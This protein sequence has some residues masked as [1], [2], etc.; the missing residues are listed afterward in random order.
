PAAAPGAAPDEPAPATTYAPGDLVQ[1][2]DLARVAFALVADHPGQVAGRPRRI[3]NLPAS[4]LN[5]ILEEAPRYFGW[6]AA[7][8]HLGTVHPW[9]SVVAGDLGHPIRWRP[10]GPP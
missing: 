4:I 8:G 7:Q 6:L 9:V 10:Q 3:A 5:P 1:P 2:G